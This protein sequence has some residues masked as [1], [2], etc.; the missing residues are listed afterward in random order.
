MRNTEVALKAYRDTDTEPNS[1]TGVKPI[2]VRSFCSTCGS[3]LW[4]QAE[5]QGKSLNDADAEVYVCTSLFEQGALPNQG[6]PTYELYTCRREAWLKSIDGAQ[7]F[8][9]MQMSK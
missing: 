5:I 7:Q 2:L 8:E 9:K 1:T 6:Q 4:Q 3:N